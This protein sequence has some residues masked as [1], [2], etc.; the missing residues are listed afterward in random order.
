MAPSETVLMSQVRGGDQN[1][2]GRLVEPHCP[3]LRRFAARQLAG[4]AHLAEDVLQEAMLNAYRAIAAGATPENIKA[5]LFTLVRNCVVNTHRTARATVPLEDHHRPAVENSASTLF[6]QREWMDWLMGAIGDLPVRQ[7][8]A[9]LGHAFEGRSYAE[10]ATRQDTTVSAVKTLIHRARRGLAGSASPP[11]HSI[12]LPIL[13]G[14]R[15]LGA[16]LTRRSLAGKAGTTK[17][18]FGALVPVLSAATVTTGVLMVIPGANPGPVSASGFTGQKVVHVHATH[19]HGKTKSHKHSPPHAILER[20]IHREGARATAQCLKGSGI[21]KYSQAGLRYAARHLST[22][23]LEYTDCK[24]V[25]LNAQL[26]NL[27]RT[28]HRPR[29][30]STPH[31]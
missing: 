3:A 10:I 23:V 30:A 26:K 6:A 22:S 11:W 4:N 20:R 7:R 21:G 17:G 15:R 27:D 13:A 24:S 19:R 16:S 1:A 28:R 25:L 12:S 31:R 14:A 29:P 2:F 5:W 9:L 8:E 18:V